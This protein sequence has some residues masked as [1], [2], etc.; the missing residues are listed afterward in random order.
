MSRISINFT[1]VGSNTPEVWR[2]SDG[3]DLKTFLQEAGVN[4]AKVA[5]YHNGDLIATNQL[6]TI[7]LA[8]GDSVKIVA[9]S[10]SSGC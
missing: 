1:Q 10:Y 6:C 8:D 4:T 7:E 5:V 9:Q 2:D 3:I